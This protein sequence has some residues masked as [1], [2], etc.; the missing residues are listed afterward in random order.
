V[1]DENGR[2]VDLLVQP[3]Q[4]LPPHSR[5]SYPQK[6]RVAAQVWTTKV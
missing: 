3:P 1:R 5:V 4:P 2:E 6:S